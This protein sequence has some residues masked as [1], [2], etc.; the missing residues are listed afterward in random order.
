MLPY[1]LSLSSEHL[2]ELMQDLLPGTLLII[3]VGALNHSAEECARVSRIDAL[4]AAQGSI[5]IAQDS[6]TDRPWN[7][8]PRTT[9]EPIGILDLGCMQLEVPRITGPRERT[10]RSL[11]SLLK[12][13]SVLL[14][15]CDTRQDEDRAS[16]VRT[17]P[18]QI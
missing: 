4:V 16:A 1:E 12:V 9:L 10:Q 11:K 5:A 15:H 14:M 13:V 6:A 2:I 18:I 3:T 17:G 8:L 7:V